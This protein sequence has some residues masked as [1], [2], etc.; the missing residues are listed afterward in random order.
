MFLP[1]SGRDKQTDCLQLVDFYKKMN[2]F[3]FVLFRYRGATKWIHVAVLP[4][5]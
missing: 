2:F 3:G 5:F 4:D 1:F